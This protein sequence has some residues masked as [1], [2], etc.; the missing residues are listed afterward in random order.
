MAMEAYLQD[1]YAGSNIDD[2]KRV[3]VPGLISSTA[4]RLGKNI[5]M[6]PRRQRNLLR[7]PITGTRQKSGGFKVATDRKGGRDSTWRTEPKHKH[8]IQTNQG[9]QA[10]EDLFA[11][12]EHAATHQ[13][14]R[15]Y[16]SR[17]AQ[18][19]SRCKE[20]PGLAQGAHSN[21]IHGKTR[22]QVHRQTNNEAR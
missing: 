16:Y 19:S 14:S 9:T 15:K 6:R 3:Q 4:E 21:K 22:R 2:Q 10:A 11:E 13:Q 7:R 18:G 8:E 1:G 12:S 20:T 5:H 17:L